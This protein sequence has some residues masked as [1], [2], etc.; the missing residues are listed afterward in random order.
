MR[1]ILVILVIVVSACSA[2]KKTCNCESNFDWVRKTIEE[3]DAG[4]QYIIDKKGQEAY[5]VHNQKMTEKVKTTETL[6]V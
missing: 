5:N 2:D 3:S 6:G 1:F 4:F